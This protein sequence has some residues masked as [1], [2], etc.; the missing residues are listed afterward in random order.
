MNQPQINRLEMYKA[1][2]AYLDNNTAIWS[3]IPIVSRY[4]NNLVQ[5]IDQIK[6]S[7]QDQ[8]AAKVY[9]SA[10]L[11]DLKLQVSDKI[12]ILDDALE[13]YADDIGNHEL[14]ALS[15]NNKTSYYALPHEDFESKAKNVIGLLEDNLKE[16][17]D[18]GIYQEQLEDVKSSFNLFQDRRGK[19]R[20]Y[21]IASRVATLSLEDL[22]LEADQAIEKLDKVMS[23]F[24][25]SN[26]TF[27]NGYTAARVIVD[28]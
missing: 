22:M 24:R 2:N 27:F 12:D 3:A 20:A 21:Q 5:I 18:F 1:T 8:E 13:A 19:P 7:A 10:S 11:K 26:V 4:K 17:K 28:H 9:L 16:L 14:L 6:Q 23:R 15:S 25:R